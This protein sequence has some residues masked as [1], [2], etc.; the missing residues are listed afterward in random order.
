MKKIIAKTNTTLTHREERFL[1]EGDII[2]IKDVIQ[3]NYVFIHEGKVAW[4][5][6]KNF[7]IIQEKVS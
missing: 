2:E 1:E 5:D 4:A 3:G 7:E 6:P